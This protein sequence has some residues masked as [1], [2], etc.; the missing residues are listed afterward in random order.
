[1]LNHWNSEI[2]PLSICV[3]IPTFNR[4]CELKKVINALYSQKIKPDRIII[5]DDGSD[6]ES[7]NEIRNLIK[8]EKLLIN[9]IKNVPKKG[10]SCA[11]NRGIVQSKEDVIVFLNDDTM[12]RNRFFLKN[13]LDM[14]MKYPNCSIMGPFGKEK[15]NDTNFLYGRWVRQ[16]GIER[17]YPV[18][19]GSVL[20][21]R[22]FCTANVC[23][24]RKY[25][26]DCLF[27]E[28]FPYP[29]LEDTDLGYRLFKKGVLLRYNGNS[30]VNHLHKYTIEKVIERQ[31]MLGESLNYL[32][33]KHPEL[34]QFYQP[35]IPEIWCNLLFYFLKT[36]LKYLLN[37]DLRIFLLGL[38]TKYRSYYLL[39]I[40]K[41]KNQLVH[42]SF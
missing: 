6:E 23:V 18:R 14:V 9:L 29:A 13:H 37:K 11:R 28:N 12:P 38:T 21:Y 15:K 17:L 33:K 39:S 26:N 35:K 31:K 41:N 8:K 27:D 40:R 1:M 42:F 16:L 24:R 5:I 30:S 4:V 7:I 10:P 25:L 34:N 36:P 22:Y 2:K 19:T 32:L 20:P 3:I